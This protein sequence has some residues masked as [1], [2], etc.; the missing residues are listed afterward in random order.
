MS[1]Y[2]HK[3]SKVIAHGITGRE[4]P[5]HTALMLKA[6]TQVVGGLNARTAATTASPPPTR[7]RRMPRWCRKGMCRCGPDGA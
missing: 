6:G 1:I 4:G 5:K 2:L 3:D 7:T